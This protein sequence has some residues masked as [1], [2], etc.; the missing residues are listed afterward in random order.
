MGGQAHNSID[1]GKQILVVED[2]ADIASTLSYHLSRTGYTCRLAGDGQ[3]GLAEA[4]RQPPDLIVL[5]RMLPRL[6]GDEVARRLR[7]DQRTARIP[8]LMLT[9]R[10][11]ESDELVGFALGADDYVRKPFSIKLLMARIQALLRRD[12]PHGETGDVLTAGPIVLDRGRHE[13]TVAERPAGLT[14]MEFR[15]LAA[16]MAARGRVLSRNQLIDAALGAGAAVTDRT[17]DVHVAA[18]RK[19]LGQFHD[20]LHTVRGVGYA[21]RPVAPE[22]EK[23]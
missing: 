3:T 22:P 18:L 13:V 12:Q 6:S 14:A 19:K 11:E 4:Q 10:A 9:A 16:L 1:Q 7:S 20:W 17:I 2:E 23:A 21:F 15:L 5:D 8:I